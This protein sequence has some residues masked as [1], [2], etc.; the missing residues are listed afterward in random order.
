MST[1]EIEWH[2]STIYLILKKT[3]NKEKGRKKREKNGKQVI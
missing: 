3:K 1:E 2:N